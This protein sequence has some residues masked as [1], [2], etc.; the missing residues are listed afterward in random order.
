MTTNDDGGPSVYPSIYDDNF[1]KAWETFADKI[2]LVFQYGGPEVEARPIATKQTQYVLASLALAE[3]LSDIR[4]PETA[5]HFHTLAEALQDVV[6]GISHPL[7][8]VEKINKQAAGK[9]GRQHDTSETWRVRSSLCIGVKFLIAGGLDQD[10][11]VAFV[12]RKHR[13]Q[14]I[15]L[16]RPG[17]NLES[18]LLTWLKTFNTDATSNDVA[19]ASYKEGMRGLGAARASQ[20]EGDIRS[21]GERL[22]ASA[23]AK[24]A[25]LTKI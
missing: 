17:T 21:A 7:F 15:N 18:S 5:A 2:K 9:R 13:M 1:F 16:L 8:R 23:A 11:A 19:L 4:Q 3:L 24:A 6:E 14:L 25:K 10:A 22:V 12:I 20:S